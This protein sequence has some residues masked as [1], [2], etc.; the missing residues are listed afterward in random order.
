MAY[1]SDSIYPTLRTVLIRFSASFKRLAQAQHV[2]V[3]GALFDH[4]VV[5]PHLVEQLAAREHALGM[6]QEELQ[7]LEFG[8]ADVDLCWSIR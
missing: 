3:D 7:Q 5:A 1:F 8:V 4:D 6:G 2:D